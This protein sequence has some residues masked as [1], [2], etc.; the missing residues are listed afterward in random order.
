MPFGGNP[1]L[2]LV[3]NA[4][5][6]LGNDVGSLLGGNPGLLLDDNVAVL[7]RSDVGLPLR[8]EPGVQRCKEVAPSH[9]TMDCESSGSCVACGGCGGAGVRI[10]DSSR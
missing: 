3:D 10:G 6:L 5:L 7:L 2:L 4:G 1:G 9:E 8:G